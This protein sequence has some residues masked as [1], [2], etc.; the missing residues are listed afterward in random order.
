M[1]A[2]VIALLL[3]LLTAP[4]AAAQPKAKVALGAKYRCANTDLMVTPENLDLIREAV[5]CLHNRTR[6]QKRL[7]SLAPN[8]ALAEAATG[9][10]G[11]MV[12]R[13]YFDHETPEGDHFDQRIVDTG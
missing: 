3:V 8:D 9:H 11:D 13:G 4:A 6:A 12:A 2:S 5:E 1:R 7:R 10:A